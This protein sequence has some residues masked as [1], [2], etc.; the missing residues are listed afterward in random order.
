M[1]NG[2][3]KTLILDFLGYTTIHGLGRLAATKF[4]IQKLVW[5]LACLSS[6]AAVL[7]TTQN[8]YQQYLSLPISTIISFEQ[9]SQ[10]FPTV[11]IC[12]LNVIPFS[13]VRED[14]KLAQIV[15]TASDLTGIDMNLFTDVPLPKYTYESPIQ[16]SEDTDTALRILNTMFLLRAYDKLEEDYYNNDTSSDFI[17]KCFFTSIP[18]ADSDITDILSSDFDTLCV[19]FEVN[20]TIK[21]PGP[22][23]G[24]ELI[25]NVQQQE[26]VPFF[27]RSAGVKISIDNVNFDV[28]TGF[29]VDIGLS[30]LV[31]LVSDIG[32][33]L[34]LWIGISVLSLLE[35][36][37]LICLLIRNICKRNKLRVAQN[38]LA[39]SNPGKDNQRQPDIM[40][41]EDPHE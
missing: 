21:T 6:L 23:S 34:G 13:K 3:M 11:Q 22:L 32:G 25:V 29:D 7:Y 37:E 8:L 38:E 28:P 40:K 18:C 5:T 19:Q 4:W 2:P 33:Q 26:Y 17:V 27:S 30:T 14:K 31:N 9:K 24:L 1:A 36:L 39:L 16:V 15:E 12:N 10:R 35:V 41:V 20:D